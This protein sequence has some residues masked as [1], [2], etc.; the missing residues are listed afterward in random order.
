MSIASVIKAARKN[1]PKT[2]DMTTAQL[3]AAI[4]AITEDLKRPGL[5]HAERLTLNED[6]HV[7]RRALKGEKP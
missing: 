6:R 7:L 5:S 3:E 4:T 1:A 2:D